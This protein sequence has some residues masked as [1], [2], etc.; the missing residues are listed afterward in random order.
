MHNSVNDRGLIRAVG[1][2]ALTASII[3]MIV[4]AGIF[5]VPAAL[6]ACIGPYGPYAFVVCGVAIAAV[7][8]CLAE[9]ISRVP[10]SGGVSGVI[11][12][13]FGPMAGY[14]AGVLLLV[15]CVLA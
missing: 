4:G 9:G 6:A 5:T 2:W 15:C 1:P 7:A 3:S 8:I 13:A 10:I 14:V 12:V 11:A